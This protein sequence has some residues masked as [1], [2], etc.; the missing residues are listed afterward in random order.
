M[1]YKQSIC[2]VP[3][4]HT[5]THTQIHVTHAHVLKRSRTHTHTR[6]RC[7]GVN[8]RERAHARTQPHGINRLISSSSG[9]RHSPASS[10]RGER[11]KRNVGKETT[12]TVR[13]ST[14]AAVRPFA[15]ASGYWRAERSVGRCVPHRCDPTAFPPTLKTDGVVTRRPESVHRP[16]TQVVG[17]T[18]VR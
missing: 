6:A 7:T 18:V 10:E 11:E 2:T 8:V 13:G 15:R 16:P 3:F 5:H 9:S 17:T 1:K 14:D 12:P 4:T